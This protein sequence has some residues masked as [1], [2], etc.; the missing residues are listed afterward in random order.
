MDLSCAC[1][2]GPFRRR[3]LRVVT[4]IVT[5]LLFLMLS[6]CSTFTPEKGKRIRTVL[7]EE[8]WPGYLPLSFR[9]VVQSSDRLIPLN[10]CLKENGPKC[11]QRPDHLQPLEDT[12]YR[13]EEADGAVSVFR[14]EGVIEATRLITHEL[15]HAYQ[16]KHPEFSQA[17]ERANRIPDVASIT[18]NQLAGIFAY[19]TRLADQLKSPGAG[20]DQCL[21]MNDPP[22]SALDRWI[23][24]VE[25]LEGTAL[26][27]ELQYARLATSRTGKHVREALSRFIMDSVN[28]DD[29][30][31]IST[32]RNLA[33]A[34]GAARIELEDGSRPRVPELRSPRCPPG[35]LM[36][37]AARQV[38]QS[39]KEY[40]N[41]K[42]EAFLGV[43]RVEAVAVRAESWGTIASDR[44][45]YPWGRLLID[46]S[47]EYRDPDSSNKLFS[48]DVMAIGECGPQGMVFVRPA[49]IRPEGMVLATRGHGSIHELV[50]SACNKVFPE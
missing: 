4:I 33:Y 43:K 21:Q 38:L 11:N 40:R 45:W 20:T 48:S 50:R 17:K 34:T 41:A 26:W 27:V 47:V 1:S 18:E 42:E 14:Y 32:L 49:G 15:F 10:L 7:D 9:F 6:G 30:G 39:A 28:D 16:K 3:P 44:L 24:G 37:D 25:Q 31:M 2:S 35:K 29:R 19:A 46:A 8:V 36:T 13:L 23:M 22:A 12:K 5:T